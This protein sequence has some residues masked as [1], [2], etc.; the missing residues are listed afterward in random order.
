MNKEL[1]RL[2]ASLKRHTARLRQLQRLWGPLQRRAPKW[3]LALWVLGVS[4]SLATQCYAHWWVTAP[5]ICTLIV[6]EMIVD[7]WQMSLRLRVDQMRDLLRIKGTADEEGRT[8]S[9]RSLK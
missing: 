2:E 3:V 6:A 9:Y 8:L 7:E 4:I 5:L 1:A